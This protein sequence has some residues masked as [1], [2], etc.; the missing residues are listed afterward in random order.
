[1]DTLPWR[2][3]PDESPPELPRPIQPGKSQQHAYVERFNGTVRYEWLAQYCFNTITVEPPGNYLGP[4]RLG[5]TSAASDG[6]TPTPTGVHQGEHVMISP[7]SGL[8]A[9]C[10]RIGP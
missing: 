5:R 3:F 4:R 8:P 10:S 9:A 7:G 1:L 2:S 6:Q